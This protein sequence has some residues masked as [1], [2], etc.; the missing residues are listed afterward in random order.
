ML[1]PSENH[2]GRVPIFLKIPVFLSPIDTLTSGFG[3]S[4]E[5]IL[6]LT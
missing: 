4:K 2:L 6:H 3:F 5:Q 1:G